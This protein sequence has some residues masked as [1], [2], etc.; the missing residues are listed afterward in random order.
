MRFGSDVCKLHE[1]VENAEHP[2]Q[3]NPVAYGVLR[4]YWD[5]FI[6]YYPN[7]SVKIKELLDDFK[8]FQDEGEGFY[9]DVVGQLGVYFLRPFFCDAWTVRNLN[10]LIDVSQQIIDGK[11]ER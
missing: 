9:G 8:S 6:L 5:G 3:L 2:A 4:G 7:Y 10:L 11:S 1:E